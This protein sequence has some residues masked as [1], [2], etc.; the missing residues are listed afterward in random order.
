LKIAINGRSGR[1]GR[2]V[3][4]CIA[5]DADLADAALTADPD[6]IIDFSRPMA[7]LSLLPLVVE[8]K[9]PLIIGTTGFSPAELVKINMAA[10]RTVVVLSPNMGI[11]INVCFKA[12]EE[13]ARSLKDT[14]D[15]EA[16]IYDLH[17]A[18]KVDAPSGTAI[19]LEEA[20]KNGGFK[21]SVQHLS[22]RMGDV[23][24]EH[25][26]IFTL[27]GERI[28]L[29]HRASS[30]VNFAKGAIKAARWATQQQKPGL[31]SMQQVLGLD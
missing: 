23:I 7:T 27:P 22:A 13:M 10:E 20:I 17:H 30:R 3:L 5:E 1:M 6:V 2:A 11:G 14:P 19:K 16:A 25:Q 26:V 24:G 12:L 31:Y 21:G 28:E 4:D 8:K 29:T 9:I 15:V 18:G